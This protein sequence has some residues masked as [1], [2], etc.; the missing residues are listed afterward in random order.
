MPTPQM[1]LLVH[2]LA[3][4]CAFAYN[5]STEQLCFTTVHCKYSVYFLAGVRV[6]SSRVIAHTL[7]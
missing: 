4:A 1:T 6:P 7:L 2:L 3:F 5:C